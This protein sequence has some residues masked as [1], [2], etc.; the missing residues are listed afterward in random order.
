MIPLSDSD[1]DVS[2]DLI[3]EAATAL[4]SAADTGIPC[5]PIRS[6]IGENASVEV[7]YAVQQANIDLATSEGR[8]ISGRK[9]GLTAR[10]VQQQ[11]GVRQP[12][13][14]T[15]F[16]DMAYGD[17]VEVD[18]ER[19]IQPR[20]E[21]E[22][23]IVLG[24]DLDLE[25]HTV[26][27][28]IAATAFI[29]PAIEVVDSRVRNWDIRFVDTVADNASSGLYTVGSRPMSLGEI[30]VRQVP[31]T[32]TVNGNKVS[33]GHG[34]ACLGNPLNAAVWLADM[35]SSIGTPLQAGDC[36]LTGALGPVVDVKPGDE[37]VADFGLLGSVTAPFSVPA[38]KG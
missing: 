17:G 35:M 15:L 22:I 3:A 10:S 37:V 9:I 6:I 28:I 29:L 20:A 26:H 4:R 1:S 14:G 34:S 30:D 5:D 33:T 24:Q 16:A 38:E 32:L 13:F 27:D 19:L 23:A 31:M 21:A 36:V 25:T 7:A 2:P 11:L 8:R 18:S 12:D